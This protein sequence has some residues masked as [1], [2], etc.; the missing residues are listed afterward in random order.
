[1]EKSAIK[2][3]DTTISISLYLDFPMGFLVVFGKYMITSKKVI[4]RQVE[5]FSEPPKY[6]SD[7]DILFL[8]LIS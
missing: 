5:L 7:K 4:F 8:Y 1:M 3:S 2:I 6:A